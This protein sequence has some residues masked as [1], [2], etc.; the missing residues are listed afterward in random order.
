MA[1]GAKL[2]TKQFLSKYQQG[3]AKFTTTKQILKAILIPT[4]FF[5]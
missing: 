5:S 4:T 2:T 3:K 1:A